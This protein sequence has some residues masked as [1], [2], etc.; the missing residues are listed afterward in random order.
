M[1]QLIKNPDPIRTMY[2]H[3]RS[4]DCIQNTTGFN[5][6]LT[7]DL[8]QAIQAD[9]DEVIDVAM[10][11]MALPHSFYCISS[12]L[13]NDT[14]KYDT[15]Q[16]MT[17]PTQNYDPWEVIRVCNADAS[18]GA[19]FTASYDMYTNKVSFLNTTGSSHTIEWT[20]SGAAN[21]LGF[22]SSGD[23]TVAASATT[24]S[25]D[26]L[27]LATIH[28]VIVRSDLAQGN[29]L[30]SDSGGIG[31]LQKV[32]IDVDPNSVI[33]MNS[34]DNGT[35]SLSYAPAI[36][37]IGFRFED[38]NGKLLQTNNRNFE[39]SV[40]FHV[41][42]LIPRLSSHVI[43]RRDQVEVAEPTTLVKNPDQTLGEALT[44][45][46]EFKTAIEEPVP[47]HEAVND[48]ILDALL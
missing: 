22:S 32:N 44:G 8:L 20:S 39:F 28:S 45:T 9:P 30:T 38:Q 13:E 25:P 18:F 14:I 4:K 31:I 27:D 2:L 41:H 15:S 33:Y 47:I 17:F 43:P 11:S 23:V 46:N 1:A 42:Q 24:T 36:D 3:I 35:V 16:T 48:I 6:D 34:T 37:R 12:H 21:P 10:I 19:I 7:I 29:V 40:R 26:V 5:T